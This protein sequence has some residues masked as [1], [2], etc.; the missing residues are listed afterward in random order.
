MDIDHLAECMLREEPEARDDARIHAG[1]NNTIA[2]AVLAMET[3]APRW[4]AE[5]AVTRALAKLDDAAD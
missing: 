3:Q 4:A 1:T 5:A 2:G